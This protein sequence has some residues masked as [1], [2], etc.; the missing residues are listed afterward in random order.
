MKALSV[1]LIIAIKIAMAQQVLPYEPMTRAQRWQ[2]FKRDSFTSP[3]GYLVPIF[4]AVAAH[5]KSRPNQWGQGAEGFG[6]RVGYAYAT[7]L[8]DDSI[9]HASAAILGND[10][11]Y[12]PSKD[13]KVALRLRHA[14]SR[15]FVTR[16]HDGRLTF[17]ASN[18]ISSYGAGML[19]TYML[20]SQS[21]EP[22]KYGVR[23]GHVLIAA[24]AGSNLLKEFTPD[25][26][27]LFHRK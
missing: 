11:R 18:F 4:P 1:L 17:N 2:E 14:L 8:L 9:F 26:K 13:A 24:H 23:Q 12:D 19:A 3:D 25:I 16:A 21:Y 10:V 5:L 22:L 27:R 6:K 15:T 7:N 20:P